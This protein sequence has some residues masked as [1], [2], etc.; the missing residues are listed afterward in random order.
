MSARRLAVAG[1][2]AMA[3][4]AESWPARITQL[5]NVL[6]GPEAILAAIEKLADLKAKGVLT[7]VEFSAEKV[8]LLGRL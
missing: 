2:A 6:S 8:D 3:S 7:D 5:P 1:G 4:A